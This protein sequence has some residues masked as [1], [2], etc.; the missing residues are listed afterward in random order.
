MGWD[1]TLVDAVVTPPPIVRAGLVALAVLFA[2]WA[3][4]RGIRRISEGRDPET[5]RPGRA[6]PRRPL[7]LPLRRRAL[8][9]GR[10]G[11]WVTPCRS[12]WRS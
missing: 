10:A 1:G 12:S 11:S 5:G 8:G 6:D 4:G 3:L 9:R 2:V 7:R